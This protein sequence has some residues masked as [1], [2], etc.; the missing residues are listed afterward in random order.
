MTPP[1]TGEQGFLFENWFIAELIRLRDY[2]NKEH[3]F[4][5]WRYR[6]NEIDVIVSDGKGPI[7]SME[8]KA[9]R[10]DIRPSTISAFK[11]RFSGV[12]LI[13]V[14]LKD[15]MARKAG[16]IEILPWKQA[17]EVYL[18]SRNH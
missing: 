7:F 8:C 17:L 14:S 18:S 5:F 1:L 6:N 15:K 12:P 16:D 3:Q 11:D 13:I 4:S 9:G 2:Y 10:T